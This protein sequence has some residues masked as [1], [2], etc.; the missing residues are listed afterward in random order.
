MITTAQFY[1]NFAPFYELIYLDWEGSVKRQAAQLDAIIKEYS[2]GT[3]SSVLDVSCGI[4]TQAIGLA[5]LGYKV[6]ASDLSSAEIERA[7][8]EAHRLG[9][10]L[11]FSVCDM[12]Q[13]HSHHKLQFD[14]V[15]SGDNSVPHLLDD[16][17]ILKAFAQFYQCTRPGGLCVITVRDYEKEKLEGGVIRPY[18]VKEKNGSRFLIFQVWDVEAPLYQVSMYCVEDSGAEAKTTIVRTKY[19]AVSI[20]RLMSLLKEA[21]FSGI[22]RLDQAF[23]Q[24]VLVAK[25][26][27]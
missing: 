20:S 4:G 10:K 24:P 27:G 23:F 2:T 9:A 1:D 19:Y 25:R 11:E 16:D 8:I 7:K 14:I 22:K 18:A 13:A 5:K 26:A 6:A 12:R 3:T 15:L 21:G 17:S